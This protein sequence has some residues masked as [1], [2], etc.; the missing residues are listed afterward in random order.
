M[1]TPPMDNKSGI[2]ELERQLDKFLTGKFEDERIAQVKKTTN[3]N[4]QYGEQFKGILEARDQ[5]SKRGNNDA[6]FKKALTDFETYMLYARKGGTMSQ[7]RPANQ[8]KDED[9][10]T[11]AVQD[12]SLSIS[13]FN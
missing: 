12:V 5:Q 9:I 11:S 4:L 3:W 1:Y 2:R 6:N 10:R 8:P 13:I 7:L